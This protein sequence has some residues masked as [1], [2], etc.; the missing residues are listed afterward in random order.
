MVFLLSG[1]FALIAA[2][3]VGAFW[4]SSF[5]HFLAAYYIAGAVT[6]VVFFGIRMLRAG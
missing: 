6:F 2:L 4:G 1:F 3:V 5:A